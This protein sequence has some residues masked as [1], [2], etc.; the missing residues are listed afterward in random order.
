MG[1]QLLLIRIDNVRVRS[2]AEV[3][4]IK[5]ARSNAIRSDATRSDAEVPSIKMARSDTEVPYELCSV[6]I[7]WSNLIG[8]LL[9][10]R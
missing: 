2:D 10:N 8:N 5:M 3:P 1:G 7:V 9:D 4:S 6:K